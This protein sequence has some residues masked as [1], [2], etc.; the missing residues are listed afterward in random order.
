[1]RYGRVGCTYAGRGRQDTVDPDEEPITCI[2]GIFDNSGPTFTK[3]IDTDMDP[4]FSG[5]YSEP[6]GF[7]PKGS[8]RN[9]QPRRRGRRVPGRGFGGVMRKVECLGDENTIVFREGN[10]VVEQMV[11]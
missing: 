8:T 5:S 3:R 10:G 11:E 4:A 7:T 9:R 1:M 2:N 6:L